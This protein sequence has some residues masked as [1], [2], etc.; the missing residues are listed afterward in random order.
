MARKAGIE[1]KAVG[2]SLD[3]L[4]TTMRAAAKSGPS[5]FAYANSGVLQQVGVVM[6]A[7]YIVDGNYSVS[8]KSGYTQYTEPHGATHGPVVATVRDN[9]GRLIRNNRGQFQKQ[10]IERKL[11]VKGKFVDRSGGMANAADELARAAPTERFPVMI[12]EEVTGQLRKRGNIAIG[13]D[14]SGNGYL[15]L[16]DGYAAAERGS[17]KRGQ[18][19]VRGWW[20]ALRSVQGR[21]STLMRKK[22]PDLL[23]LPKVR[24]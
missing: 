12:A 3:T 21:W 10:Y 9:S 13:I 17:R 19:G 5:A 6:S 7:R 2:A 4:A 8:A 20:R 15:T 14:D 11:F 22:Y 18:N 24:T 23:K 1:W 16:A